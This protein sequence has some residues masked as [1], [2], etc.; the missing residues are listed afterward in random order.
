MHRGTYSFSPVTRVGA[1]TV[2][3]A[4]TDADCSKVSSVNGGLPAPNYFWPTAGSLLSLSLSLSRARARA[5][6]LSL[7]TLFLSFV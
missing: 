3:A 4:V 5:L 6:S 1:I 2:Y 7:R